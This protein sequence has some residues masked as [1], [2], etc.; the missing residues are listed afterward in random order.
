MVKKTRNTPSPIIRKIVA[1]TNPRSLVSEQYRTLRTNIKF[2]SP[3]KEISSIL[4]TSSMHSEGKSTTAANL[5]I[6]FAQEGKQVL[7]I[8]ADMRKPTMHFTFSLKNNIGLSSI[9]IR[10]NILKEAVKTTHVENLDLITCGPIP[11]NPAE[12][13]GSKSMNLLMVQLKELYDIIII[14][15]PPILAVADS[16]ILA[17]ICEG[18]VLVINSGETEKGKAMKAKEVLASSNSRLIGA[19]VNNY[20]M[21]KEKN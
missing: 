17:N 9:L 5:A 10:Q 6:V 8:D 13:L 14:D 2:S 20:K 4:V 11:P 7:I 19:V 21:P 12:L 1:Y 15:A 18:A 3:D 16:Q